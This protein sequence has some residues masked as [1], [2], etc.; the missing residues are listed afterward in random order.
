MRT[1]FGRLGFVAPGPDILVVDQG[2]NQIEELSDRDDAEVDALLKLLRRPGGIIPNP[3]PN[4]AVVGQTANITAPG[5][6]VFMRT[7]THLKLSV[8][9]CRHQMR[10]SRPLRTTDIILPR[11]K[12]LINLREEEESTTDPLLPPKVDVK[13]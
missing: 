6:S 12:A 4:P 9:Y 13:N 3:N 8:Y 10:T 2:I 5:I 1:M 7:A 11:I